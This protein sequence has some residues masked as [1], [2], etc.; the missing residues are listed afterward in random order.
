[1]KEQFLNFQYLQAL[2]LRGWVMAL[3]QKRIFGKR[4]LERV[5]QAGSMEEVKWIIEEGREVAMM[6]TSEEDRWYFRRVLQSRRW[7]TV[8]HSTWSK[9]HSRGN[10]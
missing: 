9:G 2:Y 7:H 3:E 4:G 8:T 1:M 10:K 5:H 6:V